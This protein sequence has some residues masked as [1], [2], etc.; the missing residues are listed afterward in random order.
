MCAGPRCSL[1]RVAII[2]GPLSFCRDSEPSMYSIEVLEP[3][4]CFPVSRGMQ[5][6]GAPPGLV[7]IALK[8][9]GMTCEHKVGSGLPHLRQPDCTYQ[10]SS[11]WS[12]C[13]DGGCRP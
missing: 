13:S 9:E 5:Q 11:C 6:V 12:E 4:C 2:P 1:A 10:C 8:F 3:G 7:L